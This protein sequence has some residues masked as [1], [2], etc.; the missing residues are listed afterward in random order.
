MMFLK[1]VAADRAAKV[2]ITFGT[3]DMS[4]TITTG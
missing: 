4:K 3:T 1:A 2:K